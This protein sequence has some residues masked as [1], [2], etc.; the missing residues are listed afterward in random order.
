MIRKVNDLNKTTHKGKPVS[1]RRLQ[2][3]LHKAE[4]LSNQY[5]TEHD[6]LI[7]DLKV[8]RAKNEKFD[9][10]LENNAQVMNWKHERTLE[11]RKQRDKAK[12]RISEIGQQISELEREN[13]KLRKLKDIKEK[14]LKGSNYIIENQKATIKRLEKENKA[15][16]LQAN[17][18]FDEWQEAKNENE[19][20]KIKNEY[21]VNVIKMAENIKIHSDVEERVD[22]ERYRI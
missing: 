14:A 2:Y 17:T 20:L 6:T 22:D 12:N 9:E 4:V 13:E 15:L 16:R 3:L 1:K 19:L 8:L 5:K 21:L 11:Y 7:D 10:K 18:Y